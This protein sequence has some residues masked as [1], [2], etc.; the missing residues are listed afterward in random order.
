[1]LTITPANPSADGWLCSNGKKH[2]MIPAR[3]IVTLLMLV[4]GFGGIGLLDFLGYHSATNELTVSNI[5]MW[6]GILMFLVGV[7][8]MV[9]LNIAFD[10]RPEN[11]PQL[12]TYRFWEWLVHMPIIFM[13]G[14]A[15]IPT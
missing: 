1:M 11:S 10:R 3:W 9:P 7:V 8:V 12:N 5:L 4:G 13:D 14:N 15:K 2:K 6:T